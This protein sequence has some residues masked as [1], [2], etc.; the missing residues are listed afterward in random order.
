M[1]NLDVN[2]RRH[3]QF[4]QA[5][6]TVD[7]ELGTSANRFEVTIAGNFQSL[8]KAQDTALLD[9]AQ[10]GTFMSVA[11]TIITSW[12]GL[13]TTARGNSA[14]LYANGPA[15]S[16][17][18]DRH[19]G[20]PPLLSKGPNFTLS[21]ASDLHSAAIVSQSAFN[22]EAATVWAPW[23]GTVPGAERAGFRNSYQE[24]VG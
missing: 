5:L 1:G 22:T 21:Q 9:A 17:W 12:S 13:S 20:T 10:A 23:W 7:R 15:V 16:R 6:R 4:G 8:S 14:D 19:R 11:P 3:F 24:T 18:V 2:D